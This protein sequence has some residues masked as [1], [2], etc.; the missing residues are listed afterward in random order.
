MG[1]LGREA[2]LSGRGAAPFASLRFYREGEEQEPVL[3]LAPARIG[4][5]A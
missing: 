2:L 1:V 5:H 4:G 3:R